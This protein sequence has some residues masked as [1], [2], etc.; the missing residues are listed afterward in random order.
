VARRDVPLRAIDHPG[1]AVAPSRGADHRGVRTSVL[2]GDRI[3][4]AALAPARRE[5]V[6]LPLVRGGVREWDRR[7]P[8]DIPEPAGGL[9]PLL[10][11]QDLSEQVEAL[12]SVVLR[13][14][15][16][17]EARVEHPLLCVRGALGAEPIVFLALE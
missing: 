5:E 2:L 3:R 7:P 10:L 14:V 11:N 13:V 15:D 8:R 9:A 12:T 4:V 6:P 1:V 16:R 17:V